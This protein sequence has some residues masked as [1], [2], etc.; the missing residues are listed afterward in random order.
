[1][2]R[3]KHEVRAQISVCMDEFAEL[4]ATVHFD[5]AQSA[6]RRVAWAICTDERE[7]D[8]VI[9]EFNIVNTPSDKTVWLIVGILLVPLGFGILILIALFKEG[10]LNEET[11]TISG[12][13]FIAELRGV[14]EFECKN[15]VFTELSFTRIEAKASV[16]YH[17]VEFG[18]NGGMNLE[19]IILNPE[20][21][22]IRL[23]RLGGWHDGR[24]FGKNYPKLVDFSE[25]TNIPLSQGMLNSFAKWIP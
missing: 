12:R 13:Y 24:E 18:D 5:E 2:V 4:E 19:F 22:H 11:H 9:E 23:W 1:M 10:P 16:G 15:D 17:Y 3:R 20:G 14:I 7:A 21:P 25:R 6:V 8:Y